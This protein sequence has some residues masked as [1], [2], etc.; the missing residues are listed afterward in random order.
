MVACSAAVSFVILYARNVSSLQV[1]FVVTC[2]EFDMYH[3]LRTAEL[4]ISTDYKVGRGICPGFLFWLYFSDVQ[5]S[6]AFN[7]GHPV[8]PGC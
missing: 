3:W 1:I 5:D 6:G 7:F 2:M 8:T 4:R